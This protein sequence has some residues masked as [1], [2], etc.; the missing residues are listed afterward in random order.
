MW[1]CRKLGSRFLLLD[2]GLGFY[3]ELKNEHSQEGK[4][5]PGGK[6]VGRGLEELARV[7][8]EFRIFP[9]VSNEQGI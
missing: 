7:V 2:R 4:C 3:F 6:P 1:N 5:K 8:C 9:K